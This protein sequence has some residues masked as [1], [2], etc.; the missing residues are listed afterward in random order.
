[1]PEI[2]GISGGPLRILKLK[3][4][5]DYVILMLQN[6]QTYQN[7]PSALNTKESDNY[8][9]YEKRTLFSQI[10]FKGW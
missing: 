7:F 5:A 9:S 10:N 1:M 8:G 6:C 2:T 3:K 4:I